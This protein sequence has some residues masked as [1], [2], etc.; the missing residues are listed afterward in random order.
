[1]ENKTNSKK[2]SKP[3][4]FLTGKNLSLM[5]FVAPALILY[6]VFMIIPLIVGV[7]WS[8]TDW[9]A[10]NP[11]FNFVGISNYVE[12]LTT[13]TDFIN[14]T[15]FTFK[16]T[17][18]IVVLE[19]IFALTLAVL[20]DSKKKSS[21]FFR[22]VFFMPN[23]ISMIISSYVWVFLLTNVTTEIAAKTPFKFMNQ[24]W[25]GDPKVSFYS[26]LI[27]ALWA[28]VGYMMLIYLAALQGVPQELKEAA[29]VDGANS[30]QTFFKVTLPMI[31]QSITI[32]VFLTLSAG[33]KAFDII[34]AVTRG[35][36]GKSTQVMSLNVYN[37]AFMGN[38]RF[39]FG[40]A[41][42]ILLFLLIV[43][44]TVIQLGFFK[45]REVEA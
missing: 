13:D 24:S 14:S 15:I 7:F 38:M 25:T 6:F 11:K 39:G 40:S 21:G 33:F 20:I 16:Y 2:M 32:C 22:T 18:A 37:E 35:G 5:S 27:V 19:N 44:I 45:K 29:I 12:A 17:I 34:F 31:M 8:F 3:F 9:N 10:L 23:M 26:I 42:S 28:G 43:I 41:K 30:V 36:P 1:L 4:K